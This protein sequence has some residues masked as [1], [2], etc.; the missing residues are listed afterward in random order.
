ML[1]RLDDFLEERDWD[2]PGSDKDLEKEA[3]VPNK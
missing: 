1:G 3:V 2:L